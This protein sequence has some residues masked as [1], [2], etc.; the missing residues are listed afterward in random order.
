MARI[1][2][3]AEVSDDIERI[4]AHFELYHI[5]DI[6]N[7]IEKMIQAI[8]VLEFNPL[9]GRPVLTGK[10]ELVIG[11]GLH[12][13]YLVLYRYILEVDTAFILAIRSQRELSYTSI[14]V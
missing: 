2:L 8:S 4:I 9:I 5:E 14:T 13:G 7:R 1:E 11:S 6:T 10:R 3:A 12:N